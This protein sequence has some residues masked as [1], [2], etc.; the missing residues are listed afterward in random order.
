MDKKSK[1]RQVKGIGVGDSLVSNKTEESKAALGLISSLLHHRRNRKSMVIRS[2]WRYALYAVQW[3]V[4]HRRKLRKHFQKKNLS[5]NWER[6]QYRREEYVNTYISYKLV[7]R[8]GT[9][10]D[11]TTDNK[12]VY[13]DVLMSIEDELPIEQSMLYR[14]ISRLV[15]ACG[16]KKMPESFANLRTNYDYES[17]DIFSA[18]DASRTSL[19]RSLSGCWSSTD[20][21]GS[22]EN[23]RAT[24][25]GLLEESSEVARLRRE[26]GH[27]DIL[28]S[29]PEVKWKATASCMNLQTRKNDLLRVATSS[30]GD[31]STGVNNTMKISFALSVETLELVF[32]DSDH[33]DSNSDNRLSMREKE[34]DKHCGSSSSVSDISELTDEV[35]H[36]GGAKSVG[37]DD[38]VYSLD[39]IATSSTDEVLMCRQAGQVIAT[40]Q[41]LDFVCS[42]SGQACEASKVN[43]SVGRIQIL[44]RANVR[45]IHL[46][47]E[48]EGINSVSSDASCVITP[49]SP[50]DYVRIYVIDQTNEEP[51]CRIDASCRLHRIEV[52]LPQQINRS[53]RHIAVSG[54]AEENSVT[55]AIFRAEIVE[56]YIEEAADSLGTIKTQRSGMSS[57]SPGRDFDRCRP[58]GRDF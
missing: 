38:N 20:F 37:K 17:E 14:S 41:V 58:K 52:T 10:R 56:A 47:T 6:Q 43:F 42:I 55:R 35:T 57:A 51:F 13:T 23:D 22:I 1:V 46:G 2:W 9:K 5:F 12:D 33:Q 30:E 50:G 40:L 54:D 36:S 31:S 32:V 39:P 45:L 11:S 16:M 49:F 4:Q 21:E 53:S 25:L 19:Q 7:S 29:Y 24:R 48:D 44:S 8:T 28:P 15:Y 34:E 18:D 26:M 3:E 27:S